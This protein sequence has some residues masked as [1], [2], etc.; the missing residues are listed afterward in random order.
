MSGEVSVL[1]VG[2]SVQVISVGIQGPPG[3]P[4][5]SLIGGYL[6]S[7]TNLGNND[8]IRFNSAT[9]RWVNIKSSDIV[10]GGNF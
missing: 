6:V 4:G 10:D 3:P 1:E 7:V 9:Q 8:L 2:G 5:E